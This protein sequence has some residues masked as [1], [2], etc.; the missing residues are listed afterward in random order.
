MDQG[1]VRGATDRP[2]RALEFMLYLTRLVHAFDMRLTVEGLEHRGLIE[3]ARILGADQGQGYGIAR[4]MPIRDVP[5]WYR[6]FHYDVD[7]HRPWTALGALATY[8]LWDVHATGSLDG[9]GAAAA[10]DA[11]LAVESFIAERGL[12]GSELARLLAEHFDGKA[13]VRARVRTA[14]I[15]RFT[16][17]WYEE[18]R[19]EVSK[20]K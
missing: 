17:V 1:L 7:P 3:G 9:P 4:P 19:S 14:V 10:V 2:Q 18:L 20:P 16:H 12:E 5:D 11:R 8:L 15:E 6:R 13:A